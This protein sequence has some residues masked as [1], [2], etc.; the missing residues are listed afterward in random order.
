[1][2]SLNEKLI[3]KYLAGE[4]SEVEMEQILEWFNASED[5]RKEWLKLRMV[6]AKSAFMHFSDT[7][8]V[9]RAYKELLKK[10]DDQKRFKQEVTRKITLRFMRYAA[11]ILVLIGMSVFFYKY[12]TDWQYPKMIVVATG[13]NEPVRKIMLEDSSQVWL[14]AGSR[15]EYPKRFRKNERKVSVEGKVFFEVAKDVHRPF[16]VKTE[17]YTVK[18]LGTSFEVNAFKYNQIS[19]VTLLEGNVEILDNNL[20]SLCILQPGQQFETDKLSNQFTLHQVNAE[21]YASWHGG[22]FEFDGLTFAEIVKI[23]ERHY[24]VLIIIDDHIAKDQ[25]LVGSLSF[26]K[27]I[28]QMM[29]TIEMVVPIKYHVQIDTVVYLQSKN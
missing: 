11:S 17:T 25:R 16:Y 28:S 18:V 27:D 2:N 20:A 19:D 21:M 3:E 13:A 1:M 22:Q 5:N 29:K 23:L 14:S 4:C 8:Q 7:D 15:I 10:Q 24:N 26:Q 12:T 9:A 6:S